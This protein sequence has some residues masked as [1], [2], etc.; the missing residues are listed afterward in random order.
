MHGATIKNVSNSYQV[1]Y[2][3]FRSLS[4]SNCDD[5]KLKSLC[6]LVSQHPPNHKSHRTKYKDTLSHLRKERIRLLKSLLISFV[7]PH[8]LKK[9]SRVRCR[10]S[11]GYVKQ[12]K[13]THRNVVQEMKRRDS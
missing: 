3:H 7:T 8:W 6:F 13:T 1:Q 4:S 11:A 5:Q 10:M 12:R 2:L 9:M